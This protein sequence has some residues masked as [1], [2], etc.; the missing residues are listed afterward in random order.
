MR[1]KHNTKH[2]QLTDIY[3]NC[4][5]GDTP[6]C[7]YFSIPKEDIWDWLDKLLTHIHYDSDKDLDITIPCTMEE[8]G[9]W[10]SAIEKKENSDD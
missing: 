3:N 2:W 5:I 4:Q 1:E 10:T 9:L 6:D 7:I 8:C